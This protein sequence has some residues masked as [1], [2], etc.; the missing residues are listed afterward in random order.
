MTERTATLRRITD[1]LAVVHQMN[2]AGRE[3]LYSR[4][5][6]MRDRNLICTQSPRS[7][8]K[9][10]EYGGADI[11]AAVVAITVSLS[12]GSQNKIAAIN[13]DLRTF[14]DNQ[15]QGIPAY[16]DNLAAILTGPDLIF[17][18]FDVYGE[19]FAY[20]RTRMGTLDTLGLN[21]LTC[22]DVSPFLGADLI[23]VS[24]R[25]RPVFDVLFGQKG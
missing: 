18:R 25:V 20:T 21:P 8:G 12:G 17:V 1:A 24:L 19:P 2:D 14:G 5:R 9:E 6:T 3:R 23:P 22:E 15:T 10:I 4:A 11:A 13:R 7:Q 16:E